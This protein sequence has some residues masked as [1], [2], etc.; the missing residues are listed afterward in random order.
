MKFLA[1][2]LTILMVGFCL[3]SPKTQG[4]IV[5]APGGALDGRHGTALVNIGVTAPSGLTLSYQTTNPATNAFTSSANARATIADLFAFSANPTR[6]DIFAD[7]G[8]GLRGSTSV[9]IG[10][11]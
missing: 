11:L 10:F 5:A 6:S 8:G 2:L 9:A 7:A 1:I 3:G 4:R